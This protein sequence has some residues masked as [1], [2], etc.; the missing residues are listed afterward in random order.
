MKV[1]KGVL[2]FCAHHDLTCGDS[3]TA[4]LMTRIPPEICESIFALACV[5][6]GTTARSLSLVSKYISE[7]SR[8]YRFQSISLHGFKEITIFLK[9]LNQTEPVLRRV[10]YL[11]MSTQRRGPY[12]PNQNHEHDWD[13]AEPLANAIEAILQLVAPHVQVLE[14]D[15]ETKA[16]SFMHAVT[17]FPHLTD[18]TCYGVYPLD[19]RLEKPLIFSCDSLRRLHLRKSWSVPGLYFLPHIARL[20][21]NVTHL[22]FS[23]LQQDTWVGSHMPVALGLADPSA[24][25][26]TSMTPF[27]ASVKHVLIRPGSAPSRGKCGTSQFKYSILM[28][29]GKE[30]QKMDN[31]VKLLP[32]GDDGREGGHYSPIRE[33]D[34][35]DRIVGGVGCWDGI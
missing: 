11:F 21:P 13:G 25:D 35:L 10:R 14:L 18:L 19:I 12:K 9:L 32:A 17:T 26:R 27:P 8:P 6:T 33:D 4:L 23:D 7:T 29:D 3:L 31:R 30:L 22:L 34:W 16:S 1:L 2:N 15:I 20:A 24:H 28:A 5:D